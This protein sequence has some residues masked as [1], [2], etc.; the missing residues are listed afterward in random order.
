MTLGELIWFR[1]FGFPKF[2]LISLATANPA[3]LAITGSLKYMSRET[4]RTVSGLSNPSQV[5]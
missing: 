2:D 5:G 4:A 3:G 1:N